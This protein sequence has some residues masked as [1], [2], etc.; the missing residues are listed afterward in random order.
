MAGAGNLQPTKLL[1]P[2]AEMAP[3]SPGNWL[4]VDAGA[5]GS[6][7]ADALKQCPTPSDRPPVRT[8]V[9]RLIRQVWEDCF[10]QLTAR[11]T[12]AT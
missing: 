3:D 8:L 10:P 1:P 9:S 6:G 5:R 4:K 12:S 11:T 2:P 7:R